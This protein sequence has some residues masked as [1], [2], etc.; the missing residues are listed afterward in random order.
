MTA[1]EKRAVPPGGLRGSLSKAD[2]KALLWPIL[3]RV[4]AYARL[5]W[6]LIREPTVAHRHKS[7]L[8]FTIGY[9]LS[10]LHLLAAPIPVVAQLDSV[11]LLLLGI[12]QALAHCPKEV[13]ERHLER[14]KLSPRQAEKDLHVGLSVTFNMLGKMSLPFGRNILFAGRVARGFGSRLLQRLVQQAEDEKHAG[15]R[16][17]DNAQ[18]AF[19]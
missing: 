9:T 17:K 3:K 10:P 16:R 7:L 14:L 11:L 18:L 5:G 8:Y 19:R 4:P 1:I 13:R 15:E 6:A 2:I 12:R